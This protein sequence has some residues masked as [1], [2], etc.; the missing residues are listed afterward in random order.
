MRIQDVTLQI[1]FIVK[2]LQAKK[3]IPEMMEVM[4]D[5]IKVA[6]FIKSSALS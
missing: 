4:S 5:C 3:V 6:H 1:I 2:S